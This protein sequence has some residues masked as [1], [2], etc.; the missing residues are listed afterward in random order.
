MHIVVPKE[1]NVEESRVALTPIGVKDI[2]A[3]GHKL[4]IEPGAG[5]GSFISDSA[6]ELSGA[7][8]GLTGLTGVRM[9]VTEV[10]T[11]AGPEGSGWP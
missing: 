4:T 3:L 8:M 9:G 11:G 2:V 6:F 1:S 10:I 5:T 7:S